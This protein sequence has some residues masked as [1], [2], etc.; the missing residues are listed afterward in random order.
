MF[1]DLFVAG[2]FPIF[3]FSF[4]FQLARSN[5]DL[6]GVHADSNVDLFYITKIRPKKK[7]KRNG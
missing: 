3:N 6:G 5:R 4:N 1:D 7:N 2:H